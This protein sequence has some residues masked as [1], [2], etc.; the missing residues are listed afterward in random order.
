MMR[1]ALAMCAL[2]VFTQAIDA[3]AAEAD[4]PIGLWEAFDA[5]SGKATGRMRIYQDGNLLFGRNVALFPSDRAGVRCAR[6]KDE[7]GD[8]PLIG[9][10]IMRNMRLDHG[11]YSGGD[12]LDPSTGR[13]YSCEFR[14][15]DGG[16][17]MLLRGF[18]GVS[19]L[20]GT[21]VW[22]RLADADGLVP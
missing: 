1:L 18:L 10:V 9:L 17:K 7:R 4:S 6:C 14:L 16:Q 8:Q 21:Q 2:W 20:G 5:H 19:F 22:R 3:I 12:I 11:V 15:S 13:V